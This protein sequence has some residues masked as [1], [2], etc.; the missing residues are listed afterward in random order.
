MKRLILKISLIVLLGV[1]LSSCNK[2]FTP[3]LND[4]SVQVKEN[5]L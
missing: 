4:A 3:Q 2:T 5:K 1:N